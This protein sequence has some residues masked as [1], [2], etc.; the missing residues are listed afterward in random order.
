MAGNFTATGTYANLTRLELEG[1]R[2]ADFYSHSKA[3]TVGDAALGLEN[4]VGKG[5]LNAEPFS[6]GPLSLFE[7]L[8]SITPPTS[9]GMAL[10]TIAGLVGLVSETVQW[11]GPENIKVGTQGVASAINFWDDA[12]ANFVADGVQVGDLIIISA[13]STTSPGGANEGAVGVVDSVVSPTSLRANVVVLPGGG[14]DFVVDTELYSYVIVRPNAVQLLAVPGSGPLGR[15]QT[16]LTV[17]PTSV[18]HGVVG[19][20]SSQINA[21]R[22]THLVPTELSLNN[23]VDRSDAVYPSPAPAT[24]ADKLGYRIILY[25][26]DGTGTGP[27]LTAPIASLNPVIDGSLPSTDQR[28]TIDHKAG[29]IRF[30]C[31]PELGGDIKVPGGTNATTGRLNL[32]ATFWVFDQTSTF[33][34]ARSLWQTRSLSGVVRAPSRVH[35]AETIGIWKRLWS[36]G[37]SFG[38]NNFYTYAPDVTED[39]RSPTFFGTFHNDGS[40]RYLGMHR[41]GPNAGKWRML[42]SNYGGEPTHR[43]DTGIEAK[44][45]LQVGA[46]GSRFTGDYNNPNSSGTALSNALANVP[47]G[48]FAK[49][50]LGRG[51]YFHNQRDSQINYTLPPGLQL[52]GDGDSTKLLFTGN[53]SAH[54]G[55]LLTIGSNTP[56]GVYDP[57]STG[58]AVSPTL[59][60]MLAG[61]QVEG[62]DIVWNPTRQAW[63]VFV[64]DLANDAIWFNE[65]G[66]DGVALFNGLGV[67]I[68]ASA[69]V[70]YSNLIAHSTG[71]TPGHYP[72]VA[73]SEGTSRYHVVWVE[74]AAIPGDG[75]QVKYQAVSVVDAANTS[76]PLW[77]AAVGTTPV[78]T[79]AN[80]WVTPQDV[81]YV[82]TLFSDH[83]SIAVGPGP[84]STEDLVSITY[85][86]HLFSATGL[87]APVDEVP[88]SSKCSRITSASVNAAAPVWTRRSTATISGEA[89]TGTEVV[90][91]TDVAWDGSIGWM[92]TYSVRRHSMLITTGTTNTIGE[93]VSSVSVQQFAKAGSKLLWLGDLTSINPNVTLDVSTGGAQETWGD[94]AT[95]LGVT[96]NTDIEVRWQ[97]TGRHSA[98]VLPFPFDLTL[99]FAQGAGGFTLANVAPNNITLTDPIGN[100]VGVGVSAGDWVSIANAGVGYP[101]TMWRKVTGVAPTVLTCEGVDW[102]IPGPHAGRYNVHLGNFTFALVPQSYVISVGAIDSLGGENPAVTLA[103]SP[104]SVTA[105]DV[106]DAQFE[107]DFVRICKGGSLFLA[108]WQ[109]FETTGK[110]GTV[111]TTDLHDDLATTGANFI[112]INEYRAPY[113][114]HQGTFAALVDTIWNTIPNAKT[115]NVAKSDFNESNDRNTHLTTLSLG[116]HNPLSRRPNLLY[117]PARIRPH[118][119]WAVNLS[120]F[121]HRWEMAKPVSLL[122]DITWNGSDFVV[123]SPS[124]PNRRSYTGVYVVDGGGVV[125]LQDITVYFGDGTAPTN[126][127]LTPTRAVIPPGSTIVFPG[128]ATATIASVTSGHSVQLVEADAALLNAGNGST[129]TTVEWVL[130]TSSDTHGLKNPGYRV[131]EEGR[132][133]VS[134]SYNTFA[135]E[136][137]EV[138]NSSVLSPVYDEVMTVGRGS[139]I[140]HFTDVS[141]ANLNRLAPAIDG[142]ERN[143][144]YVDYRYRADIGYQGIAVGRP[145]PGAYHQRD[146]QPFCAIAWGDN[147]FGFVDRYDYVASNNIAVYRQSFG[148]YNVSLKNVSIRFPYR[149]E[150]KIKTRQRVHTR[151]GNPSGFTGS[152]ATN[153]HQNVFL[154]PVQWTDSP[155][156][157]QAK[158]LQSVYTNATGRWPAVFT[159][160]TSPTPATVGGGFNRSFQDELYSNPARTRPCTAAPSVVW[161]GEQFV[162]AWTQTDN[163]TEFLLSLT[164]LPEEYNANLVGPVDS[165]ALRP[166][167]SVTLSNPS[168]AASLSFLV[169]DLA[170]SGNTYAVSWLMGVAKQIGGTSYQGATYGVTIFDKAELGYASRLPA[171]RAYFQSSFT[172]VGTPQS[173]SAVITCTLTDNLV[174]HG[175]ATGDVVTIHNQQNV[176]GVYQ[177]V[178]V[179]VSTLTLDRSVPDNG[180][181]FTAY[182]SKP[183]PPASG[184]TYI[185]ANYDLADDLREDRATAPKVTWDGSRYQ[186]VWGGDPGASLS[187]V[188]LRKRM[189]T[190]SVPEYGYGLGQ[191][192]KSISIQRSPDTYVG[193]LDKADA[194]GK[195]LFLVS[196]VEYTTL[197]AGGPVGS[198][199]LNLNASNDPRVNGIRVG[200]IVGCPGLGGIDGPWVITDLPGGTDITLPGFPS[201]AQLNFNFYRPYIPNV[202]VGDRIKIDEKRDTTLG[203]VSFPKI[204]EV[205]GVNP[206]RRSI[207]VS[208]VLVTPASLVANEEVFFYGEMVT[209]NSSSATY[210]NGSA[211]HPQEIQI[212]PLSEV[213]NSNILETR[214]IFR[215]VYN[216]RRK[217]YAVLFRNSVNWLVL[218]TWKKGSSVLSKSIQ[219]RDALLPAINHADLA[220]NGETYCV[221]GLSST[222]DNVVLAYFFSQDLVRTD[223]V[224][225]VTT[226]SDLVGEAPGLVPGPGY[227]YP[228][229]GGAST[230]F[231]PTTSRVQIRWN[232][233]LSRWV[234]AVTVAWLPPVPLANFPA[235]ASPYTVNLAATAAP[236]T[237]SLTFAADPSDFVATLFTPGVK[238]AAYAPGLTYIQDLTVIDRI[239]VIGGGGN[240]RLTFG[241]TLRNAFGD[242][243]TWQIY[244]REDVF[245]FTFSGSDPVIRIADAD[246]VVLENVTLESPGAVEEVFLHQTKP[247]WK[248]SG[249]VVGPSI[250]YA[251][252]AS[253]V[254]ADSG[255]TTNSQVFD[256]YLPKPDNPVIY[257][258]VK[259]GQ[260]GGAR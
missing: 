5:N 29:V 37:A 186:V 147:L 242:Y 77:G 72:R 4:V 202:Q 45:Q 52:E 255:A 100:F 67:D 121:S 112:R 258:N 63:G 26:D 98:S 110:L 240:S 53:D 189:W 33:G 84:S 180:I 185:L 205:T 126:D 104:Y 103:G 159:A 243:D 254:T 106:T 21:D 238:V 9:P 213:G 83:P 91:S 150:A 30:S 31:A 200:D 6:T 194:T 107:P 19:P 42:D 250:T 228:G 170:T 192:E 20:T 80:L 130:V 95:V 153:G 148:P 54:S 145:K 94:A 82:G 171:E 92:F 137:T 90:S 79:T 28:M 215:V 182:V 102:P 230:A 87:P 233:N 190:V 167:A 129:T 114:V 209:S 181:A 48:S 217:E 14:T 226:T 128:M 111:R 131:N 132:V 260:K 85:V 119:D 58:T 109:C 175:I 11:Y 154:F 39:W 105:T 235:Y 120:G 199:S 117:P 187:S 10:G 138:D 239:G 74:V 123:V 198:I 249:S 75:P 164:I 47:V 183:M 12:T 108:S 257:R 174:A 156:M 151:W 144:I 64:A 162:A 8:P 237:N 81:V 122:P 113:R 68:K 208:D 232:K 66:V 133:I 211:P 176:S 206:G 142:L 62:Y 49:V 252:P 197:G 118:Y 38:S 13:I 256:H 69:A 201:S 27:D 99:L 146:E 139:N 17:L 218:A 115:L 61:V 246:G 32:Y 168:P 136:I 234:G 2:K 36:L 93:I 1:L 165:L 158:Y 135:D 125:T 127:S 51:C 57:S 222:V 212:P 16:F 56:W 259:G 160:W 23:S 193:M 195:T 207:Q 46:I 210:S 35:F 96:A 196:T 225:L 70:L 244:P 188:S 59:M 223:M 152:M 184:R 179:G 169:L 7:D 89:F 116:T 247:I 231:I 141:N 86:E 73:Y 143:D 18:L 25:P 50:R 220:F 178:T 22:L 88:N 97:R 65:I 227:N 155:V 60:A 216:D 43:V 101:L 71:H 177:V 78:A 134:T 41:H 236:T 24:A 124:K 253:L 248:S 204:Y 173:P 172:S 161:D 191:Q 224:A 34:T 40:F 219:I 163:K 149:G 3:L 55:P 44:S 229:A 140:D 157:S 241:E 245:C 76:D 214:D 15:E 251:G 221:L 166:M 203:L